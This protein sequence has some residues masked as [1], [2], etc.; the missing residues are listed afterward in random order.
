[1]NLTH[2]TKQSGFTLVEL[3]V[4]IVILGILSAFA[5]PKFI[6]LAATARGAVIDGIAGS[7]R[8]AANTAYAQAVASGANVSAATGETVTI[9]GSSVALAYGYPTAAAIGTAVT[10]QADDVTESAGTY[11]YTGYTDC[12]VVYASAASAGAVPAITVTST[13]ATSS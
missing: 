2:K 8:A 10:L 13:C 12:K 4:V 9:G 1:M 7:V 3:V 5:I 6:D 11:T